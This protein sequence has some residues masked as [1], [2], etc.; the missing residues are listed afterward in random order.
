MRKRSEERKVGRKEGREERKVLTTGNKEGE[1]RGLFA[2]FTCTVRVLRLKFTLEDAIEFH[3][4]AP[5]EAL[6]CV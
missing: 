3:A 2:T 6:S 4:F 5:L 1:R